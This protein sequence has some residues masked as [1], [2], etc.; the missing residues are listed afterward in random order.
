[1]RE[2]MVLPF[3]LQLEECSFYLFKTRLFIAVSHSIA[4]LSFQQL[5]NLK[6]RSLLKNKEGLKQA[7]K[8]VLLILLRV[9]LETSCYTLVAKALRCEI[10]FFTVKK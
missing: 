9:L 8:L 4:K 1:M 3:S 2:R 7:T 10:A 6:I 5:P